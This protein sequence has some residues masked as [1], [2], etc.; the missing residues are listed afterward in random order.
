MQKS[1][2][3]IAVIIALMFIGSMLVA[4]DKP[5]FD[6]ENCSFCKH[7]TKDPDLLKNMTW[8]NYEIDNG[9]IMVTSVKPESKAAYMEAMKAME[10]VGES[11][12]QGNMDV[13]MCGQCEYYGTLMMA[14][15]KF[16][17]V[18]A[19]VAD[20]LL[21]TSDDPELVTKIKYFGTKNKEEMAKL[22]KAEMEI[23]HEE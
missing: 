16:Q 22:E 6:L 12:M 2:L 8:D 7:L 4:E 10:A 11:M 5:W 23:K 15:A 14:G 17:H 18:D 13:K 9:I 20:I 19:G 21:I 3:M 1:K